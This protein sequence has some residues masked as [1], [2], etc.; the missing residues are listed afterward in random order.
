MAVS[1]QTF[2]QQRP[3][4]ILIMADDM[5][6]SDIG[7]YGGEIPTP[8]IDQLATKGLRFSQF[9]NVG[10]CCPSR[11][12]L[13][14]GLAPHQAGI[15][16]MAED[17]EKTG[18]NDWGVHGYRGY[19]NRNSVTLA[20]VLKQAGYHTYM[21]GK[22]H[23]GMHG[24]EKWPVGRGFEQF[25]GILSG[26]ASHLK[27]FPPRGVTRNDGPMEYSFPKDF[28]DTDAFTDNAISFIKNQKDTK[29][30]FLY[31][32]HTAPHWPLQA[33][34][35]DYEQF[36]G[37][38]M[39]GWDVVRQDRLKKQHALGFIKKEWGLASRE[40]R[41]WEAL[42]QKEKED[43]DFRMAVYAAQM[44]NMDYNI[45]K[46]VRHLKETGK[47][48]NT[49]I[50]FLSDNGAC[51]EPYQELGG[52]DQSEV[53]D[54]FKFWAV[55]YGQGWANASN[56]PFKRFK[57]ETYEG[58]IAT[59][60]IAYWPAGI[61]QQAGKWYNAPHHITDIMPT[62]IE[63]AQTKYP[64]TFHNGNKIIPTEGISLVPAFKNGTGKQHEYLYWE[65]QDNCAIRWGKWKAVKKLNDKNW[66]LYDLEKDRTENHNLAAMHPDLVKKLNDQWYKWANSHHVL[67]K[68]KQRDPYAK[69]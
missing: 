13:L 46:L 4:I 67:P 16:H 43:V 19:L 26:G 11:A 10:R 23:V 8:N 57:V 30:F 69:E 33:K 21:T 56:T 58:G 55:S 42:T 5:G 32:A 2:S 45:G 49:L 25:Y 50:M 1:H 51:A 40:M 34:K 59:P 60:F 65:H 22:W 53:N 15:G 36:V 20:E 61:K 37:K 54:P 28:Y 18:V 3:N 14:T 63:L 17:P 48:D 52:K 38:Y 29:P 64:T 24:K 27:P 6:F 39:K 47:L 44:Y 12:A 35:E 68:G 62:V 31:L 7:S 9:Y 66:E 41:P